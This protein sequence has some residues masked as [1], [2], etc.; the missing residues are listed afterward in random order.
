[1]AGAVVRRGDWVYADRD[2]VIVSAEPL[3][4]QI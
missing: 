4:L 3:H 1:L 2:G